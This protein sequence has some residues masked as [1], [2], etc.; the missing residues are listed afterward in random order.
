MK[1]T[2][3]FHYAKEA[4]MCTTKSILFAVNKD[5][6]HKKDTGKS[7]KN[8]VYILQYVKRHLSGWSDIKQWKIK[9]IIL[10][11]IKLSLSEQ[12]S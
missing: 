4:I 11:V 9:A 5:M 8:T 3:E 6:E 7:I 2:N 12:F 1:N 10:A